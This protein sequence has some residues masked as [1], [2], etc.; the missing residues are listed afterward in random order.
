MSSATDDPRG[1]LPLGG[2]ELFRAVAQ[3][4][5]VRVVVATTSA[6]AKEGATRHGCV[7]AAAV[8]LGRGLTAG[9]CLATLTKG[10]ERVTLQILSE[11][12]LGGLTVDAQG[13]GEVRG[14]LSNPSA[15]APAGGAHRAQLGQAMGR[16]GVVNVLRDL[17]LRE[18]Y[19]GQAQLVTGEVDEDVEAYLRQSEQIDSA[20]GCEV[21]LSDAFSVAAAAGILVQA[22]PPEQGG[23]D[24]AATLIREVQH[25]LRTGELYELVAAGTLEAAAIAG[26]LLPRTPL[27]I[28]ERLPVRFAC[29]CSVE[30]VSGALSLLG[31]AELDDMITRDGKAEVFCNFCNERYQF[32]RGALEDLRARLPN[33]DLS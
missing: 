22:L 32:D 31:A 11:G 2:D 29:K 14:Y 9:L 15:F 5:S 10:A 3:D 30:R 20:L 27:R 13:T 7:G 28:L 16:R 4:G 12:P 8:A 24:D 23:S 19:S 33:R 1:P 21:A 18:Q 26:H 25:R 17:G 6:V